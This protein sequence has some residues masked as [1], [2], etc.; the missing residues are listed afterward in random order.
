MNQKDLAHEQGNQLSGQMT[1]IVISKDPYC[2]KE[3]LL[4]L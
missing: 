3:T 2:T 1:L 4:Q